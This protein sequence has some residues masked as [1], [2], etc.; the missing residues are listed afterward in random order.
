MQPD[1][2]VQDEPIF[3]RVYCLV[4]HKT[5][6]VADGEEPCAEGAWLMPGERWPTDAR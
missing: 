4:C 5:H 6:T 2:L 1:A 3:T